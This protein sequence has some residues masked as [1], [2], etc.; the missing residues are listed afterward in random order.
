M[1]RFYSALFALALLLPMLASCR[2]DSGNTPDDGTAETA[3]LRPVETLVINDACV[4]TSLSLSEEYTVTG[5]GMVVNGKLY[6][7]VGK[8]IHAQSGRSDWFYVI[9][10][11]PKNGTF[12]EIPLSAE[13]RDQVDKQGIRYTAM[14][15]DRMA[16]LEHGW[17]LDSSGVFSVPVYERL[18][19]YGANGEVLFSIDP[20][21]LVSRRTNPYTGREES[22]EDFYPAALYYG[23][24][25]TLYM[26]M[27]FSVIA[28][29]PTGEKIYETGEGIYINDTWH[30]PDGRILVNY[31]IPAE[32]KQLYAYMEDGV[33]GFS[34]PVTLPD[35]GLEDYTLYFGDGYDFYY[36]TTDGFYA[37]NAGD[38]SPAY[39]FSWSASGIHPEKIMDMAIISDHLYY[40]R[41]S[42]SGGTESALLRRPSDDEIQP[43]IVITL[44]DSNNQMD[45]TEAVSDFN[46]SNTKYFIRIRDYNKQ[47]AEGGNTLQEDIL[48]GNA[49]DIVCS[50]VFSG[51]VANLAS[52]GAFTD[53]NTLLDADPALRDNLLGSV[54]RHC[55]TD[56][57]LYQLASSVV[58]YAMAGASENLP[59]VG[60]WTLE[61]F[62]ALSED[63]EK[64]G[65]TF[66]HRPT[67]EA[68]ELELLYNNLA[69]FVD[70]GEG[71]CSFASPL[72]LSTIEY[73]K[74]LPTR[75]TAPSTDVP[76]LLKGMRDGTILSNYV[77]IGCFSDYLGLCV[78]FDT[79]DITVLGIPTPDG[80]KPSLGLNHTYS[81]TADSPVKEEAWAFVRYMLENGTSSQ[82][83]QFPVYKPLLQKQAKTELRRFHVY[84]LDRNS[85]SHNINKHEIDPLTQISAEL[86]EDHV[87]AVMDLL[88]NR[89]LY[90]TATAG[91]DATVRSL[92]AEELGA[93]YAGSITAEEA[94]K[95]IQSRVSIYLAEQS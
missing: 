32:G 12:V 95:R 64:Q 79:D 10:G 13:Y 45:Y 8:N 75:E 78:R 86:T 84:L 61:K 80:G 57:K 46:Q 56:G 51:T 70:Y 72:F 83:P 30:T 29:S 92:I 76:A 35:P 67:R 89:E 3:A 9:D 20:V 25:G 28:I 60:E 27:E 48:A 1:K 50:S 53:L 82:N 2:P 34:A 18:V 40:C 23:A 68:L 17:N 62:L 69:T 65:I 74:S 4:K 39:L 14:H 52:K 42:I 93:Y 63:C 58:L 33:K 37:M 49:P 66:R 41:M 94:A 31:S 43:R 59:S 7:P 90:S 88:E 19:C 85:S 73:L 44:G 22:G 38:E 5:A 87:A 26:V 24:N 54:L 21:S 71:S 36:Q 77:S 15:G 91:A 55:T 6:L 16:V 81:I 47:A 11:D